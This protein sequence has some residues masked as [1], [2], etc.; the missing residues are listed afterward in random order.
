[1]RVGQAHWFALAIQAAR[2]RRNRRPLGHPY[3]WIAVSA[4]QITVMPTGEED[5]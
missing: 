2:W 1:V 4:G 5:S 3:P